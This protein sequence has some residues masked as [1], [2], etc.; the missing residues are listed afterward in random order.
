MLVHK[1]LNID[2]VVKYISEIVLQRK[3]GQ[4]QKY[5]FFCSQVSSH[6]QILIFSPRSYQIEW[7]TF[8]LKS[9][10]TQKGIEFPF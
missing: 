8:L 2:F 6:F 5:L 4:G 7:K 10:E 9:L 1:C 3:K